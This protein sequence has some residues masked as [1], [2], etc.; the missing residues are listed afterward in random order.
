VDGYEVID[1]EAEVIDS[2]SE[3][4]VAGYV[5]VREDPWQGRGLRPRSEQTKCSDLFKAGPLAF[6]ELA[7]TPKTEDGVIGFANRYGALYDSPKITL[8]F[9]FVAIGFLRRAVEVW[10][11]SKRTGDFSKVIRAM[12]EIGSPS[13]SQIDVRLKEDPST[14]SASIC[15]SPPSLYAALLVQL[16]LAIDGNLNLRTCKQ[17]RKWFTLEAGRGRS[18]KEYCSN[19][20]RMRAYRKRKGTG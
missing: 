13:L 10:D 20:C 14:G 18:D 19:A 6:L 7:Q 15:L 4:S 5:L 1:L 8:D 17:C 16:I 11:R 9:W 2:E 3:A 12:K